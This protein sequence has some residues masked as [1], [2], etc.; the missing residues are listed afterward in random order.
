MDSFT[1][2]ETHQTIVGEEDQAAAAEAEAAAA[3]AAATAR[4]KRRSTKK[5]CTRA[6]RKVK[7]QPLTEVRVARAALPPQATPPPSTLDEDVQSFLTMA[8]DAASVYS[9]ADQRYYSY[10]TVKQ[11]T[12]KAKSTATTVLVPTPLG[13]LTKAAIEKV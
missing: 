11:P 7:P 3:A 5:S 8:I 4:R 9:S 10:A 6:P 2:I 13:K 1:W 12:K